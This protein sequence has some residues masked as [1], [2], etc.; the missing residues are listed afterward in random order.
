[1]TSSTKL[2]VHNT[3][4]ATPSEEDR[5]TAMGNKHKKFGEVQQ[6]RFLVMQANRQIA[7]LYLNTLHPFWMWS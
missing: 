1:M 6:C 2:E 7:T 5:A 3:S 4:I